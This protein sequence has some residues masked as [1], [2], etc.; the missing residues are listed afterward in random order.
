MK[1]EYRWEVTQ[2]PV[3]IHKT[4]F[5]HMNAVWWHCTWSV[6]SIIEFFRCTVNILEVSLL[7]WSYSIPSPLYP[8]PDF[9]HQIMWVAVGQDDDFCQG[10]QHIVLPPMC[11]YWTGLGTDDQLTINEILLRNL[12]DHMEFLDIQLCLLHHIS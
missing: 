6:I 12:P 2:L 4:S 5:R 7:S 3:S 11:N 1:G 8:S 9:Y 10:C